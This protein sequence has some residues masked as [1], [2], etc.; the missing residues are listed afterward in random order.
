MQVK[1]QVTEDEYRFLIDGAETEPAL[2]GESLEGEVD[3]RKVLALV[4][5][6][7]DDEEL[8]SKLDFWL[9]VDG[10]G[11]E[12]DPDADIEDVEAFGDEDADVDEEDTVVVEDEPPTTP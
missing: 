8:E 3:G 5:V 6:G 2:I 9:Y 10:V 4:D 7:E 1:M 12:F 11:V